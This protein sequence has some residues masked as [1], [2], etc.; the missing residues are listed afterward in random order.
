MVRVS[1]T[2]VLGVAEARVPGRVRFWS[3]A[4]VDDVVPI[5]SVELPP[6]VTVLGLKDAVAPAGSPLALSVIVCA[7]P[8]VTAVLKV[9][10]T[11]LPSTTTALLGLAPI[12][13]KSSTVT[14]S[15]TE[16][17]CV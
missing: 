16:V 11:L 13:K 15:E 10:G 4:G 17:L 6:A 7:F 9:G 8:L 1:E 3:P 2:E 14:V 5:V 12:A